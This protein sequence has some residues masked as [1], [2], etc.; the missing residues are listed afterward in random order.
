METSTIVCPHCQHELRTSRQ[1]APGRHLLCKRCGANFIVPSH[2]KPAPTAQV[3]P[4]S[5]A[6]APPS[7]S[8]AAEESGGGIWKI[9][10]ACCILGGFVL[11]VAG[12][13]VVVLVL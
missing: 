12:A 8:E 3:V 13:A 1:F 9:V 10:L 11:V 7:K 4:L 6:L 5:A 2:A